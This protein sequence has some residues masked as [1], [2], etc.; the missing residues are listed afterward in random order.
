[1]IV[2]GDIESGYCAGGT[3]AHNNSAKLQSAVSR[4]GRNA[5]VVETGLGIGRDGPTIFWCATAFYF[6]VPEG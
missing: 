2:N 4:L 6:L 1:M 5:G 3:N